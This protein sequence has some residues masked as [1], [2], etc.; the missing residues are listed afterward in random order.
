MVCSAGYAAI[1]GYYT[2]LRFESFNSSINDLGFYNQLLWITIHGG[3]TAWATH[4]QASF[5]ATYPWQTATFLVLVPVY[6]VFPSP[7]TLLVAQATGTALAAIPIYLLARK[8][9]ISAW[10]SF[11]IGGC[12]LLNFQLQAVN[13]NDFHLQTFYPLTFFTMVLFYE[14]GW[15][16][17][18]V[19]V[20]TISLLTNPLTLVLTL[21]F[22]GAVLVRECSPR[23]TLSKLLTGFVGWFRTRNALSLLLILGVALGAFE[24]WAGLVGAYHF[25]ATTAQSGSQAYFPTVS[26]RLIF[27]VATFLPF[28]FAAFVIRE[29]LVMMVPLAAFLAWADVSFFLPYLGRQDLIEFL[30]VALWGLMLFASRANDLWFVTRLRKT[31][32]A[33]GPGSL[34]PLHRPSRHLTVIA[35]VVVTAI[36]FVGLSPLSPWHQN[37]QPVN[38]LNE[39]PT[40]ITTVTPADHF[41][42]S[43]MALIPANASVLTQNNIVQLTGRYSFQWIFPGKPAANLSQVGYIL[44]DQSAEHFAQLWYSYLRPYVESALESQ[45]FGIQAIGYG[46]LLLQRGY[47]GSPELVGPLSYSPSQMG[48]SSGY[49]AGSTAV[50]P[51]QNDS[52]FWYGPFVD[53]P[54]GP[55]TASF[56]LM[57]GPGASPSAPFLTVAVTNETSSGRVVYA[58]SA[59]H[60]SDFPGPDIWTTVSFNFTLSEFV[61]SSEFPGLN[62]TNAAEIYFGGVT[63]T[64]GPNFPT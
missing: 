63:V 20:G 15:K 54:A 64:V 27:L 42:V 38:N 5:Y 6:A 46:V 9:G 60:A 23:L 55:Y 12:Y 4:A 48:L 58:S 45:T 11:G 24:V 47:Q 39:N 33:R 44:A 36:C 29:T 13:L 62:A 41:L 19:V 8:Y 31:A 30:V 18:F 21:A 50:H 3:P 28:L 59:L 51:A 1:L 7:V 37:T 56:R 34:R 16:K 61:A 35:A 17:L 32:P 25:G 14:Y 52:L 53:L 10:A 43:A 2:I 26:T 22:L 49:L 40:T 57:I